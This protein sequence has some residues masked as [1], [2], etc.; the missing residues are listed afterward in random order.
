[1]SELKTCPFCAEEIQAAAIV[2]KHCSRNLQADQPRRS[3]VTPMRVA[4]GAAAVV[5]AFVVISVVSRVGSAR[6]ISRETHPRT[7]E[8]VTVTDQIQNVPANSWKA[9]P[10]SLPYAG[11]LELSLKI[12]NGNPLDVFVAPAD[13]LETMQHGEWDN[14]Q[15]YTAFNATKTKTLKRTARLNAGSYY[16]VMRDTSLGIL[17]DRASDVAVKADLRP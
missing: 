5:A 7:L 9:V 12:V 14:V 16:L 11:D 15:A 17:S 4:L 2:C 10:L 3:R 6:E 13:Q 1:M 8:P